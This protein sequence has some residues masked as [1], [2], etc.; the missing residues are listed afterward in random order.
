MRDYS[1]FEKYL[2]QLGGDI[3][4]QPPDPQHTAW[5]KYAIDTI[6]PRAGS[7]LDVGCGVGF[8]GNLFKDIGVVDWTGVTL[9]QE[10]IKNSVCE[11]IHKMDASFLA[12]EDQSFDMIFA[13]H[14]L[15]H[16]PMPLLT[17]MEWHRVS[18]QYLL[19]ILPDPDFWG[20]HGTNH[21][22]VLP[23]NNWLSLIEHSR[24]SVLQYAELTTNHKVFIDN[25][26]P[27]IKDRSKAVYPGRRKI[28]EQIYLLTKK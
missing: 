2:N 14:I 24:W 18:R 21:Y 7:V 28:L 26:L 27:E 23:R 1:N 6:S 15:E 20:D 4:P 16:S 17:L 5:A 11:P 22:Y 25:Y 8:C 9:S 12:F 13:R 19:L 3:Y 10:D